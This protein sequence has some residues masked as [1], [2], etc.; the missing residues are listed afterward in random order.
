MAVVPLE[1]S[2]AD[3]GSE[4]AAAR[5]QL[6]CATL[7][8]TG[9]L[10]AAGF[11]DGVVALV[12]GA[13][14]GANAPRVLFARR[15]HSDA[16]LQLSFAPLPGDGHVA[17]RLC[18]RSARSLALLGLGPRTDGAAAELRWRV[19]RSLAAAE[20]MAAAA[21]A[22]PTAA[23]PELTA[24]EWLPDGSADGSS[25]L[26]VATAAGHLLAVPLAAAGAAAAPVVC[27]T[28]SAAHAVLA[29]AALPPRRGATNA[30]VCA[31]CRDGQL[32]I[33]LVDATTTRQVEVAHAVP[34]H[35]LPGGQLAVHASADGTRWLASGGADGVVALWDVAQL[36]PQR[37]GPPASAHGVAVAAALLPL[38]AHLATLRIGV[39]GLAFSADGQVGCAGVCLS[40]G[41][42]GARAP[43]SC[44]P[45]ILLLLSA[46]VARRC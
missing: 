46:V 28:L 37:L 31:L 12:A 1:E 24:A 3:D 19:L 17:A 14:D 41:V 27:T 2:A 44:A 34:A 10:L 42:C 9:V 29:L 6:T 13:A 35:A 38:A 20:L 4:R 15:L 26:L 39:S 23:A 22:P 5:A 18:S 45:V 11:S 7:H 8:P 25:A 30:V 36:P 32:R 40:L 21:A 43:C 33:L 16:V